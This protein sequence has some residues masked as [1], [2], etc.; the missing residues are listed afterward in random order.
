MREACRLCSSERTRST[1][2]ARSQLFDLTAPVDELRAADDRA[3]VGAR[4]LLL[5]GGEAAALLLAF[6]ILAAASMRRDVEAA[7]R[8]LT[9]FG[10]R[11]WQL[12]LLTTAEASVVALGAAALGWAAGVGVA[13]LVAG[14]IDEPVGA[15]LRHS[16][17]SGGGIGLAAGLAAA[18]TLVLVAALRIRPVR[19]GGLAVSAVDVAALG[20]LAAVLVGIARGS[21]DASSLASGSGTGTFLLLLPGLVAFVAA[22]AAARLLAPALRLLERRGRRAPF[23][24]RTAALSLARNPGRAAVASWRNG[25]NTGCPSST[26]VSRRMRCSACCSRAWHSLMRRTPCS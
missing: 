16:V 22:V 12:V 20:V 6:T 19:V 23:A 5:I 7:W 1:L 9:W 21:A 25:C 17:L 15:V 14:R 26:P 8:R 2:E 18:A 13:A 3:T 24:F 11:R 10:A 4:R